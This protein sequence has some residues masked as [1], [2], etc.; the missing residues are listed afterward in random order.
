MSLSA[1]VFVGR[2]IRY[3]HLDGMVVMSAAIS[4]FMSLSGVFGTPLYRLDMNLY[5]SPVLPPRASQ[6]EREKINRSLS[7]IKM[8]KKGIFWQ[9]EE[10]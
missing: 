3:M 9:E 4:H 8:R 10:A 2:N 5:L 7:V 6:P 1:C